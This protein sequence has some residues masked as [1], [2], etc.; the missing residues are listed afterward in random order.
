MALWP[1]PAIC[2]KTN[3]I[4]WLCFCP[5]R[6]SASACGIDRRL[7]RDEALQAHTPAFFAETSPMADQSLS[8]QPQAI[9]WS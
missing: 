1:R 3:H 5:A 2:G 8:C 4:Q 7:R 6:N 9:A